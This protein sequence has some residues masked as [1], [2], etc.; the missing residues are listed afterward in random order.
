M[1]DI[2]ISYAREDLDRVRPLA[3]AL[4]AEGWS[5]FWDRRIPPGKTWH[6]LIEGE[7]TAARVVVVGWSAAANRSEWVRDEAAEGRERG[8]LVPILLEKIKPPMGFR[9]IQAANL[10]DWSGDVAAETFSELID[11]IGAI[12]S[13]KR[14]A[15]RGSSNPAKEQNASIPSTQPVRTTRN[16]VELVLIPVGRF[17][18][19][20]PADDSEASDDDE[21][22]QHLVEVPAF[23][24]GRYPVTNEEYAARAGT[25]TRYWWGDEVG[26]NNANCDGCRS[27]WD[28][29][30]ASPVGSFQ[31]NSF[32]LYDM[33]G[34]VWE[35]VQDCWHEDY[36]DGPTDGSAWREKQGGD[37]AQRVIRGGSWGLKPRYVRSAY[38]TRGTPDG[39]GNALGFRLAQDI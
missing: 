9:A 10:V 32:G 8:I 35:W 38:R 4:E 34:N 33:L 6:D 36:K 19:G 14:S 23:Y 3:R 5:V 17:L 22:P 1:S 39:R 20:S 21:Y 15:V 31:P 16:G 11:A 26:T 7:L 27:Q 30:Q 25:T 37:C 18:M 28:N 24:L 12:V 13:P 29:K 2:F